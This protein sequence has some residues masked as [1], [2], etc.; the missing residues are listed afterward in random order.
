MGKIMNTRTIW[1]IKNLINNIFLTN[2]SAEN[3][4]TLIKNKKPFW[5]FFKSQKKLFLLKT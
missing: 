4:A 5:A 2:W 1:K 3:I